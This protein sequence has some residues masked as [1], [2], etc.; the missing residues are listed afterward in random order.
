MYMLIYAE[1]PREQNATRLR[2]KISAKFLQNSYRNKN[3][4][5]SCQ[6]RDN[7]IS[8][9][10]VWFNW[11]NY[12]GLPHF[13]IQKRDVFWWLSILTAY[14]LNEEGFKLVSLKRLSRRDAEILDCAPIPYPR[15]PSSAGTLADGQFLQVPVFLFKERGRLPRRAGRQTRGA[16]PWHE[17]AVRNRVPTQAATRFKKDCEFLSQSTLL[18]SLVTLREKRNSDSRFD[19]SERIVAAHRRTWVGDDKEAEIATILLTRGRS[20]R[21][22]ETPR[23]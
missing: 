14:V 23:G 18:M 17:E 7:I 10:F 11:N 12:K 19:A 8:A 6:R 22:T 1:N 13:F 3:G 9:N 20:T 2:E 21:E 5:F 4:I 15:A 16:E